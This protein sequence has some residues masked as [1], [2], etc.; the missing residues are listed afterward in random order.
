MKIIDVKIKIKPYYL[1][2]LLFALPLFCVA[3]NNKGSNTVK[4][5]VIATTDGEIDDECSMIRFLLYANEWDVE[6]IITTSS[7]Y[8]WHGHNWAGDDWMEPILNAYK[9]VYPNLVKNSPDYPTPDYIRAHTFLGNVDTEGEMDKVTAG[10]QQIVRV[11]LD[12]SDNRPV[13]IQ[14]WGGTNTLA[15]ALKTIEEKHPDKMAYVASKLRFY[16]IW[17]QDN[18]Y[19]SYIKPHWGKYNI[20]T[21]ISDQ[22]RVIAYRWKKTLPEE[23]HQY[24]KSDW[25][26]KNI[27]ENQGSLCAL[28]K[29][30]V[31]DNKY[32]YKDGDFRSEGDSPSYMYEIPTGLNNTEHPNWGSWGGRYEMVRQNTWLDP[33]YDKGYQYPKG[34]LSSISSWTRN[35]S[36]KGAT[37]ANKDSYKKYFE[38]IWRWADAF[39]N[40]FAAR[41]A[42]CVKSYKDAN[43]APVVIVKGKSELDKKCGDNVKL[44]AKKTYDPDGDNFIFKW[45]Q[46][47]EAGTYKGDV[48]L[49][50]NNTSKVS[51]MVPLNATQGQTI[52]IICEVKD[53]GSPQLT[54]YNRFVIKIK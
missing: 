25:M 42:W 43:H 50:N 22:F 19:Q 11:L 36:N 18:T 51:F 7:Q 21:I 28:Y 14:A 41:A 45:W 4:P 31:G 35:T 54:R 39:Q 23:M 2:V 26:K 8:H 37:S 16:F 17:E 46:Y 24:F 15:R 30:H 49:E 52:H 29:A 10:S 38:P 9:K 1:F 32:G 44:N 53:D 34:R 5:R 47:K 40:D 27:L 12:E 13:W 6:G 3:K 20:L 48:V 33:V